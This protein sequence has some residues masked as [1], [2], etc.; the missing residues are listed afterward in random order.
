MQTLKLPD[1]STVPLNRAFEHGGVAYPANWATLAANDLAGLGFAIVT[2][3][4]H[5]PELDDEKAGAIEM[6]NGAAAAK[7]ATLRTPGLDLEYAA[8]R[9]QAAEYLARVAG[10]L[11]VAPEQFP[12]LAA[13]IGHDGPDLAAVAAVVQACVAEED[14]RITAIAAARRASNDAVLAA[15][16]VEQIASIVSSGR[17]AI[18]AV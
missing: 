10:N 12:I 15:S 2:G 7:I 9:E 14:A 13:M 18:E 17:A 11:A 6:I 4:Q 3:A 8:K 1:G 5:P 16:S